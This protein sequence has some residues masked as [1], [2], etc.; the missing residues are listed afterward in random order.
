MLAGVFFI[1]MILVLMG[2]MI[3]QASERTVAQLRERIGG[4]FK[5]TS[6][7]QFPVTEAMIE[8]I[9]EIDGIKF[10]NAMDRG[11]LGVPELLLTKGRFA[12]E[13]DSKAKITQFIS[14]TNSSQNEYFILRMFELTEGRHVKESDKGKALISQNLAQTNHLNIGD[15]FETV[16]IEEGTTK[17]EAIG[18]TI[19]FEVVGI[20]KEVHPKP[21]DDKTAECDI[22]DNF[23]FID[24]A[25]HQEI[26]QTSY[27]GNE[28][29]YVGGAVFFV[30]DP[31]N[32]NKI[33]KQVQK[34]DSIDWD[35]FE[36]TVNNSA[37]Q[38]SAEPLERLSS[39]TLIILVLIVVISIILLAILLTLWERDRI[40]EAGVF[41]SFGIPKRN[42]LWQHFIE[43]TVLFLVSFCLAVIVSFP[44]SG[45]MGQMLYENAQTKQDTVSEMPAFGN[46]TEVDLAI[47]GIEFEVT[48]H[49]AAI[50]VSGIVGII[51]VSVTVGIAFSVIVRRKP[52]ELLTIM[53]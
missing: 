26:L 43:C 37:Y 34:M 27:G 30:K 41:M 17:S 32:L 19:S 21:T 15:V 13:G 10:C 24:E 25:T 28:E 22:P 31:K 4:Y 42:I 5:V 44:I 20:F 36:M 7:Y 50:A 16:I 48:L 1:L 23:I 52:K 12:A 9:M 45:K 29:R 8:G 3:N 35:T 33:T 2:T 51:I 40:H 47:E 14:N 18:E 39:M 49:P 6:E 53:E 11:Y 46:E 38:K